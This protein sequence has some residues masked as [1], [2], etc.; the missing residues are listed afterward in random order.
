MARVEVSHAG[1]ACEL[2]ALAFALGCYLRSQ[3]GIYGRARRVT[4]MAMCLAVVL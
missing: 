4:L 3:V 2:M 1:Q